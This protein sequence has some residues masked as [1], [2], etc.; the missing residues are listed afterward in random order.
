M[1]QKYRLFGK[2]EAR[3]QHEHDERSATG[4]G[5]VKPHVVCSMDAQVLPRCADNIQSYG[6]IRAGGP[7]EQIHLLIIPITFIKII[8]Y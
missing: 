4:C 8:M 1:P 3:L 2:I 6:G 7:H 5:H